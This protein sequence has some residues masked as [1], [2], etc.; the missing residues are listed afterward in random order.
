MT[1]IRNL[2][3]AEKRRAEAVSSCIWHQVEKQE[4]G[5]EEEEEEKR[6]MMQVTMRRTDDVG[7][8]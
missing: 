6:R 8:V 3:A 1:V 2:A 5:E 4:E 7:S